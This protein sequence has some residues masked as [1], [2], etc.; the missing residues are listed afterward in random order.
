MCSQVLKLEVWLRHFEKARHARGYTEISA[1]P[2][3]CR[4][5]FMMF[6][7]EMPTS[8]KFYFPGSPF[9]CIER[10]TLFLVCRHWLVWQQVETL[11]LELS[12][13]SSLWV[14]WDW[15]GSTN[16]HVASR[17]LWRWGERAQD[18]IPLP[19]DTIPSTKPYSRSGRCF[20]DL[21]ES[22]I[23]EVRSCLNA[24]AILF[25]IALNRVLT[26]FDTL[27]LLHVKQN[28]A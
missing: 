17:R 5:W 19:R 21:A 14:R 27:S 25:R 22:D 23:S 6:L 16:I 18:H 3:S 15:T 28:S 10:T 8:Q 2:R 1:F 7:S 12:S 4:S 20:N 11:K 13:P 26:T 9:H 24:A